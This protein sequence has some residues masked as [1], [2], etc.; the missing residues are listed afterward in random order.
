MKIKPLSQHIG[1][2]V[3]DIQLADLTDFQT[4][5]QAYLQYKV[6]FFREQALTPEQHLQ[7]G[8]RFGQLEPVHP[9]FPHLPQAEQV[10]VIETSAGNP[11]GKS[12]W[13]TD[14]SWQK[15]PSRC[16]ILHA[17]HCPKQGGDTIWTSMEAVWQALNDDEKQVLRSYSATHA[18][19][20]FAG[21]KY[22]SVDARGRSHVAR[23]SERYPSV[24]HPLVIHHPE[25]GKESLF[26]NEQ[27]TRQINELANDE[28]AALLEKLFALVRDE[29]FQ[30]RFVWQP[31]SVAIWDNYCTAHYAVTDYGDQPRR[32]HRVTVRGATL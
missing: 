7:L 31:G 20:A 18:L 1:A 5:Y 6:L 16:S 15:K 3:E 23:V 9:F 17:Q 32:L 24:V 26:V 10:V 13:H 8:R 21:S 28:S 25:T 4:L 2:L 19:H 14:L 22:D 29:A 12:Y 11:P 27:F 30:V